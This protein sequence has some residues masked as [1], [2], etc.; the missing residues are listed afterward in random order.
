MDKI[1]AMMAFL[2]MMSYNHLRVGCSLQGMCVG[3]N[4]AG[5]RFGSWF[6]SIYYV[7]IYIYYL[8]KLHN[9]LNMTKVHVDDFINYH[10]VD[11]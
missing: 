5:T 8:K 7:T 4:I 1:S 6:T 10:I 2:M 3:Y 11:L 9:S